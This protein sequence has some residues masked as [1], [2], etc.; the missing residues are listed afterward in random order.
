M[1]FEPIEEP[2]H[3]G[4]GA[5]KEAGSLAALLGSQPE[6]GS[7]QARHAGQGTQ[8][9]GHQVTEPGLHR[10]IGFGPLDPE[11]PLSG[12]FQVHGL[13]EGQ[14]R[15]QV[16]ARFDLLE[17]GLQVGEHA[18]QAVGGLGKPQV[19][20]MLLQVPEGRRQQTLCQ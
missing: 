14:V 13:P 8:A 20:P 12:Q 10:P 16:A 1:G 18:G 15:L 19:Q 7:T 5:A 11:P 9:R 3:Q 17:V 2:G 6:R 4:L